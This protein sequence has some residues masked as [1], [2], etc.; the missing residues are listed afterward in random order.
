MLETFPQTLTGTDP[1]W[2]SFW[3]V[4]PVRLASEIREAGEAR[5]DDKDLDKEGHGDEIDEDEW[6]ED[7]DEDEDEEDWDDEDWDEDEDEDDED[8]FDDEDDEED[9]DD[10]VTDDKPAK[11]KI[12]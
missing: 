10:D 4:S 1:G 8:E 3:S 5:P 11:K 2:S 6:D 12:T 9:Y 7:E